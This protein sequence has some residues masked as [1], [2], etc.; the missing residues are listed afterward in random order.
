MECVICHGSGP[1]SLEACLL[2]ESKPM[3]DKC[4]KAIDSL[5]EDEENYAE[6]GK[7]YN[8]LNS[9]KDRICDKDAKSFI[10]DVLSAAKTSGK[11]EKQIIAKE[12]AAQQAAEAKER[13]ARQAADAKHDAEVAPFNAVYEYAVESIRDNSDGSADTSLIGAII[14]KYASKGWRLHKT[15]VN[16]IGR[17]SN[18]FGVG[19]VASGTNAT[20]EQTILVFER[21]IKPAE[22]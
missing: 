10:L 4:A 19:G 5:S 2:D 21:M 9:N 18:S 8:W 20:I 16:E 11:I 1:F 17:E 13:A 6:W 3:C 12:R 7:S 15:L 14:S 22:K